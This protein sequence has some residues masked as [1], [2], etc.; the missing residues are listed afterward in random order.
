MMK[1]TVEQ[2]VKKRVNISFVIRTKQTHCWSVPCESLNFKFKKS[3]RVSVWRSDLLVDRFPLKIF[4]KWSNSWDGKTIINLIFDLS[5]SNLL[6]FQVPHAAVRACCPP[7]GRRQEDHLRHY[8]Q[9]ATGTTGITGY[10]DDRSFLTI[11][12]RHHLHHYCLSAESWSIEYL[13]LFWTQILSRKIPL[14]IVWKCWLEV[15]FYLKYQRSKT[16]DQFV[17]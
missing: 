5:V 9:P 2:A 8:D 10:G 7:T 1:S 11:W 16:K 3:K 14:L 15:A 6:Q 17:L 13:W 4:K 12:W